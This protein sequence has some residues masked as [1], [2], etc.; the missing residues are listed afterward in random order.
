MEYLILQGW[1]FQYVDATTV[2]LQ[3]CYQFGETVIR[4]GMAFVEPQADAFPLFRGW[5]I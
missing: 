4:C 1:P 2:L 3:I 5:A